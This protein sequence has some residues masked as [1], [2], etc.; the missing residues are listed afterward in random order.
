MITMGK[1][2]SGKFWIFIA[3]KPISPTR[4]S[5][6][7]SSIAGIGLRM[8]QDETFMQC[9]SRGLAGD[10]NGGF[11]GARRCLDDTNRVAI[12][13]ES[14]AAG[15]NVLAGV[16]TTDDLDAITGTATHA[17]LDLGHL[18]FAIDA[19]DIVKSIPHLYRR[20]R[21][22]KRARAAKLNLATGKHSRLRVLCL[23]NVD[24]DQPGTCL[25]IDSRGYHA[26]G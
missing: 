16:E 13:E 21:Q 15:N 17:H 24:I 22:R 8:D 2:M 11:S 10:C 23:R 20:L 25:R 1:S 18:V 7:K 9:S 19:I 4:V 6:R 12:G 5:S 3:R 14:N 26:N